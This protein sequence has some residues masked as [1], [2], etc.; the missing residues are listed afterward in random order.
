MPAIATPDLVVTPD[1]P[2][3]ALPAA[4]ATEIVAPTIALPRDTRGIALTFLATFGVVGALA[5]AQV[6]LVS[7]L[8]GIIIAYAL[9]PLVVYLE[10]IRVPRVAATLIVMGCVVG[11][12]RSRP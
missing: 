8:L 1:V 10:R 12:L 5:L 3:P 6:V 2:N 11:A 9:N 4:T 7:L